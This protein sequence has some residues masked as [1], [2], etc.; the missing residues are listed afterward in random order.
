[1]REIITLQLGQQSNYLAT[2]FWNTQESYFTYG[3]DEESP[4]D[5]NVHFRPGLGADGSDTFT[6]RTVIY[7]LKGGFGTLRKINALYEIGDDAASSSL[8]PGQMVVHRQPPIETS[9]FQESLDTGQTPP[10]L[11]TSTVRYWS[12]FNRI[13][14]HPRSII[15][16]S[17]YELNSTIQPFEKW[18]MG[19]DLFASLDKE[20]DLPDRDLRPFVEEADQMQGFQIMTGIDDAWGGFAAKY[21]E[22]LRDEYGKIPIWVFGVQEPSRGLP[23]E[24]RMLKLVNKARTLAELNS[25]ASLVVPLALPEKPLPSSIRLD[26]SSPWHVSALFAAALESMTLYTRLKTTDRIYSSNLGNMADLLNV[27]GKQTIANLEMS[28][29]ETPDSQ[30]NGS[31]PRTSNGLNGRGEAVG[32]GNGHGTSMED[33]SESGSQKGSVALDIDLSSPQDLNVDPNRRRRKRHI[34]SQVLADRGLQNLDAAHARDDLEMRE[35]GRNGMQRRSKVHNYRSRMAF[36]IIDSYPKIFAD[37]YGHPIKDHLSVQTALSTDSTVTDKVKA[38]RTTVVRSLGLEDR[39]TI[40]NEL[41]EI[42]DSYK[43]GW[44]SDSDE[45]DDD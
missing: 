22:R 23:R 26:A 18:H 13:F 5:H 44:S 20:H 43:E 6:P 15:Q 35:R 17:E 14:F 24:K 36:P 39:E 27:F 38:L 45:D 19:E 2:H 29:F 25:Q 41:A 33:D 3:T 10:E 32:N 40:G 9:A 31:A 34:F 7:D 8:W 37:K 28:I 42:A 21:I 4:I 1:M 12:D 30:Q 16:L 11:N